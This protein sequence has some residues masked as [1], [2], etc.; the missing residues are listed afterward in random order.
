MSI[1]ILLLL[2]L[3]ATGAEPPK[4]WPGIL[5]ILVAV[6]ALAMLLVFRS[7]TDST[8]IRVYHDPETGAS[9]RHFVDL[10]G[11]TGGDAWLGELEHKTLFTPSAITGFASLL[12]VLVINAVSLRYAPR[13][14][15]RPA[16]STQAVNR[17][18]TASRL[19]IAIGILQLLSVV[20]L[21]FV[22]MVL[23][24]SSRGD[25][26]ATRWSIIASMLLIIPLVLNV[27]V[28]VSS[29]VASPFVARKRWYRCAV[30]IC[31]LSVLPLSATWPFTM[32]LAI[33]CLGILL[34]DE[35]RLQFPAAGQQAAG[36]SVSDFSER[37]RTILQR[38]GFPLN[39]SS[40]A[41]AVLAV[42]ALIVLL[43]MLV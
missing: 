32:P 3:V 24:K 7:A 20:I 28:G 40:T 38:T 1:V 22:P 6:Y 34:R 15:P 4:R 9:P 10:D 36:Q 18:L 19:L 39:W 31:V 37:A 11:I 35:T 26:P 21:M 12:A 41:T 5:R 42:I 43:V 23:Y 27:L 13:N 17:I 14:E 16:A 2:Q 33:W 30:T 8:L 29:L 25:D